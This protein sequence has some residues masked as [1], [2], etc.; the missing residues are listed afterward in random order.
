MHRLFCAIP[1]PEQVRQGLALWQRDHFS[2]SMRMTP[3]ENLHVTVAFF[4]DVADEQVA[5]LIVA[6]RAVC[7]T[8]RALTLIIERTHPFPTH[9]PQMWWA[10]CAPAEEF[11]MLAEDVQ[12][13]AVP[14]APLMD[15]KPPLAHI[16]LARW[17]TEPRPPLHD[18]PFAHQT[19]PVTH[20]DVMESHLSA[21]GS[22]FTQ[23]ARFPLRQP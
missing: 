5:G 7:K 16:T 2:P 8:H 13:A 3:Q 15:R 6:L 20:C 19:I 14:F 10:S 18:E 9:H 23:I 12:N 22:R 4:G 1:L 17:K 21:T 11:I